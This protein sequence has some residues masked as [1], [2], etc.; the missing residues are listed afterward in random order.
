V[1][2]FLEIRACHHK[3]RT[4]YA[5]SSLYDVGQIILMGLFAVITAS[6]NGIAQVDSNLQISH[7]FRIS[8]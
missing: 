4:A 3:F 1:F 5:S 6:E 2:R 7:R 8:D